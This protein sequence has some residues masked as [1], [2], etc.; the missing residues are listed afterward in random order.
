VSGNSSDQR[1]AGH[2]DA[3]AAD[4]TTSMT[5]CA[6]DLTAHAAQFISIA[7]DTSLDPTK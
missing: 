4:S 6:A 3:A 5:S 7:G 1:S 2:A